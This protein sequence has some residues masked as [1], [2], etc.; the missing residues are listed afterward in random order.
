MMD[1]IFFEGE[2]VHCYLL[3]PGL[4]GFEDGDRD[5]EGSGPGG[6][7]WRQTET[8]TAMVHSTV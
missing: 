3:S 6:R 5:K 2:R 7:E 4:D 1:K 8:L